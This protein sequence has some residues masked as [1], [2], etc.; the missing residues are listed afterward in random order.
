MNIVISMSIRRNTLIPRNSAE[1]IS[2]K[3]EEAR[4]TGSSKR[5]HLSITQ[6]VTT[7]GIIEKSERRNMLCLPATILQSI[8]IQ[9]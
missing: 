9:K 8:T 4:F 2:M 6:V 7:A 1:V 5:V 3:A